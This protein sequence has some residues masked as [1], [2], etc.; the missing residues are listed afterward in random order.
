MCRV[1][2]PRSGFPVVNTIFHAALFVLEQHRKFSALVMPENGRPLK[3]RTAPYPLVASPLT[4][5]VS[6]SVSGEIEDSLLRNGSIFSAKPTAN[7]VVTDFSM[8]WRRET[9][10]RAIRFQCP[11]VLD[12]IF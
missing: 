9:N 4:L 8:K 3:R 12:R 11:P 1:A 7:P 5:R 2:G 10:L 6:P